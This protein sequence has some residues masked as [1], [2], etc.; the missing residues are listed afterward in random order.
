[1]N[2]SAKKEVVAKMLECL[3]LL[4]K[5]TTDSGSFTMETN[6]KNSI[7]ICIRNRSEEKMDSISNKIPWK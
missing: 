2:D 7:E 4:K 5:H 3:V 1:M 6:E